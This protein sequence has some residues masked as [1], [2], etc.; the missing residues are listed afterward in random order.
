M[1]PRASGFVAGLVAGAVI[2]SAYAWAQSATVLSSAHY[3]IGF[4]ETVTLFCAQPDGRPRPRSE[5]VVQRQPQGAP[6]GL[7]APLVHVTCFN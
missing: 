7:Q 5:P 4:G 2:A 3:G 1:A 6:G